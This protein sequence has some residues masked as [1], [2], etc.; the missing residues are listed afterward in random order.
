[1][2]RLITGL[3]AVLVLAGCAR[4]LVVLLPDES[5]STGAVAVASGAGSLVLKQP[6]AEARI[7]PKGIIE[8]ATATE[9]A[10]QQTFG[11]ALAAQPPAPVSYI[12]Y[13]FEGSTRLTPDSQPAL[14]KLL[15]DVRS[16]AAVDVQVTG[17]T[18]RV[19]SVADN[20]RL[21][22]RRAEEISAVLVQLGLKTSIIRAVGR[23]EREPLV[24]T[25]DEVREPR[26]RRVE[27]IVR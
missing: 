12:L 20:D 8:P 10:V 11:A 27:V 23:G 13:F 1:M 7:Y 22:K 14:E 2:G 3:G 18:D 5:G 26:N 9:E 6:L 25:A 21:S 15:A 17:H 19:G 24:A 4:E 16:R